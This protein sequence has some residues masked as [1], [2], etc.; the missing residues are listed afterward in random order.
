MKRPIKPFVVEVRKG[1]KTQKKKTPVTDLLPVDL[2]EEK[3]RENGALRRAEAVLF[4][5]APRVEETGLS[6]R[7]GRILESIAVGAEPV[8]EPIAE[9]RRRGR[10]P[11]ARNK[12]KEIETAT[13][14]PTEAPKRRGR[15]PQVVEGS[16]RKVQLT[17]ELASAALESIAKAAEARPLIPILPAQKGRIASSA[18]KP[19]REPRPAKPDKLAARQAKLEAKQAKLLAKQEML[20]AKQQAK[21]ARQAKPKPPSAAAIRKAAASKPTPAMA[22]APKPSAPVS[23]APGSRPSN[24][25]DALPRLIRIG[26]QA[27]Q[28][29]PSAM[30]AALQRP[31]AGQ[32]WRRR[33]RGAAFFAYER[34]QRKTNAAP[35]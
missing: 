8:E 11:G 15:P 9:V 4:K 10:P 31:P 35:R 29:D 28:G 3:P 34:R 7:S 2:F 32:R 14:Q 23:P 13:S 30:A 21:L 16:V 5:P 25:L 6:N 22:S 26:L 27:A 18:A 24:P 19:K 1:A 33:L 12:P 20:E 17:P